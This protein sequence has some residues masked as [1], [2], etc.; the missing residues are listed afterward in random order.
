MITLQLTRGKGNEEVYLK[1]PATPA[2]LGEAFAELDS[3]ASKGVST[4]IVG[5]IS[6]VY[7]L[8]DYIKNTAIEQ[9]GVLDKLTELAQKLQTMDRHSCRKFE[10]VLDANSVNGIDDVLRL[11]ESL[12]DYAVLPDAGTGSALGKYLVE[13]GIGDFPERVRPYLDYQVIGAEFYANHGGAFC[14]AGYVVREDELPEQLLTQEQPDE[15]FMSMRLRAKNGTYISIS[16]PASE[17]ELEQA[18]QDLGIDEFAEAEIVV[19]DYA[20][21]YLGTMI[22]YECI[23]IEG[24][25]ELTQMIMEMRQTDGELLKF[26]SV[27]EVEQPENFPAVLE[28]ALEMDDYERVPEDMDEYGRMVLERIGADTELLDTI[29]GFMDFAGFGEFSMREDGVVR[30]EF[31]FVRRISEPFPNQDVGE[32]KMV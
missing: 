9:P 5:M 11:S 27:L 25:N 30:T 32:M 2:E 7:N 14:R 18:K 10:G 21:P 12:D 1:L 8:S 23:T 15:R 6:N 22:P 13:R 24:A 4:R 31:G 28:L 16:L 3:I 26:L 17:K 20:T 29:D 19:I